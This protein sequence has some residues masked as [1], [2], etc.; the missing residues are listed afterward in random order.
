MQQK[1][2][3]DAAVGVPAATAWMWLHN[4]ETVIAILVGLGG[5]ALVIVRLLIAWREYRRK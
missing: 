3:I 2:A 5:L 4:V 1:I